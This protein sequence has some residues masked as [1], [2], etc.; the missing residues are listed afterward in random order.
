M[1]TKATLAS[2]LSLALLACAAPAVRAEDPPATKGDNTTRTAELEKEVEQ[3]KKDKEALIKRLAD[4]EKRLAKLEKGGNL[5]DMKPT[6]NFDEAMVQLDISEAEKESVRDA[7]LKC[8]KAQVETLE[9]PTKD[10]RV[11]AEELIDT[12]I[13]MQDNPDKAEGE[14]QKL[15]IFMSTEKVPGDEKG[16]TYVQVIEDHKKV[17]RAAIQKVLS[18]GD[19]QRLTAIHADWAEFELGEDDPFTILYIARMN[20]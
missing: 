2:L 15:F 16:R 17:M 14:I 10:K 3:L 19:Q 20:K 18:P 12:F 6:K 7:V 9:V 13:K 5:A 8:K 4:F 1:L 11:L